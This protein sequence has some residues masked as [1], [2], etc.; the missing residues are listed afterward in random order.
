MLLFIFIL[1]KKG[2]GVIT[3]MCV[4]VTIN[5]IQVKTKSSH[6]IALQSKLYVMLKI[7]FVKGQIAGIE[8]NREDIN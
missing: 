5:L 1:Y 2:I 4:P 6:Q 7:G 3:K 8:N